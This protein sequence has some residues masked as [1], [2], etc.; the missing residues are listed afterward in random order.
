M[1]PHNTDASGKLMKD[2]FCRPKQWQTCVCLTFLKLPCDLGFIHWGCRRYEKYR[3]RSALS[4]R[5]QQALG[6]NAAEVLLFLRVSHQKA[7]ENRGPGGTAMTCWCIFISKYIYIRSIKKVL[8]PVPIHKASG[9]KRHIFII[10][11][12]S[13]ITHGD[14][15]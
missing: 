9:N 10:H 2:G 13:A 12:D 5:S 8:N 11:T 14:I 3:L 4:L 1:P 7:T 15:K 6:L